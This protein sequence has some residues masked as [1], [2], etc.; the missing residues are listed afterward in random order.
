MSP[1]KTPKRRMALSG[2]GTACWSSGEG[3]A[4]VLLAMGQEARAVACSHCADAAA[5]GTPS[6]FAETRPT[7]STIP[8]HALRY[9]SGTRQVRWIS[10]PVCCSPGSAASHW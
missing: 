2:L 3:M 7:L 1:A 10:L 5:S 9:G 4:A 8:E 6:G